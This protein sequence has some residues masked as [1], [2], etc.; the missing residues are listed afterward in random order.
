MTVS[1]SW[2]VLFL[3]KVPL[4]KDLFGAQMHWGSG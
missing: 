3:N 1:N 4:D 2:H